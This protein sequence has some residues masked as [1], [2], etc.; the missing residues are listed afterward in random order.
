MVA[1]L[2]VIVFVFPLAHVCLSVTMH[3]H[4]VGSGPEHVMN[5]RV[6]LHVTMLVAVRAIV[7]VAC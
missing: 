7:N 3:V 1:M 4:M 6:S 5:A 2:I